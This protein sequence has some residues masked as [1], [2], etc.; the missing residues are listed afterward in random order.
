MEPSSVLAALADLAPA[1]RDR[2][3]DVAKGTSRS[4]GSPIRTGRRVGGR[5]IGLPRWMRCTAM[6]GF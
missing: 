6:S 5:R 3:L 4:S 1:G 2:V